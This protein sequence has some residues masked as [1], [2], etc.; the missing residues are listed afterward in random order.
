[1]DAQ[2]NNLRFRLELEFVQ[3]LSNPSYLLHLHE[4]KYLQDPL[5][6]NYL[7]YLKYWQQP[8]Y[9]QYILFPYSLQVLELLQ[10]KSFRDGFSQEV[11]QFLHQKQYFHW[12]SYRKLN[13]PVVE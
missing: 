2:E 7:K 9:A 8:E 11:G 3:L 13:A 10:L 4:Q 5:F 1:M 6:I 12:E